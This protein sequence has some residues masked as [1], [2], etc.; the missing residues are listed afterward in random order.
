MLTSYLS[1]R[2]QCRPILETCLGN[3]GGKG[4]RGAWRAEQQ[5]CVDYTC[6][7][8]QKFDEVT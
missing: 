5:I 1:R 3:C 6:L 2:H 8:R 4:R 7:F